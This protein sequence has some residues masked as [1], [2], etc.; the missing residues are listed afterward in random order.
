MDKNEKRLITQAIS[1]TYFDESQKVVDGWHIDYIDPSLLKN[2]KLWIQKGLEY[3]LESHN[4]VKKMGFLW[5]VELAIYLRDVK[6]PRRFKLRTLLDLQRFFA[7]KPPEILVYLSSAIVAPDQGEKISIS[8]VPVGIETRFFQTYDGRDRVYM[9][10][11]TLSMRIDLSE[12]E[13]DC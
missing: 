12:C 2:K 3:F 6:K 9:R 1:E 5:Q 13:R 11:L 4:L 8:D 7:D 10:T